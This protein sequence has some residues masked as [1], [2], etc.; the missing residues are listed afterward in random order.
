MTPLLVSLLVPVLKTLH[1]ASAVVFLGTGLGSAWYRWRA[2][3]SADLRCIAWMQKEIVLADWLFTVP[4]GVA[5]PVTGVAMAWTY[6]L[7]LG[8]PWIAAGIAGYLVAGVCWL[9][10]AALQIRMRRLAAEALEADAALPAAYHRDAR[11]WL[12]LGVPSFLAA[13]LTIWFMVAKGAAF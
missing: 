6:G 12:A 11:L 13:G 9:P 5:L 1:V 8:T 2:D 3:R 10:A 4:S 7:P